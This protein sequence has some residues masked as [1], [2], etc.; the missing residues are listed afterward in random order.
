MKKT[1]IPG[2]F[3]L[4]CLGSTLTQA[5]S[6]KDKEDLSTGELLVQTTGSELAPGS[7]PGAAQSLNRAVLAQDGIGNRG[8]IDQR[9][10]GAGRGNA[11]TIAQDGNGNAAAILQNGFG[12]RTTIVQL[13]NNNTA[14]SEINGRNTESDIL[15][16]G[17][18]NRVDQR[19][20]VD[21]RRYSVE[22][23]GN[24]NQLVQRENG[25]HTP[26]YGVSMKG[27]GIRVIVEQGKVSAM[28]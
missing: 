17:N 3:V 25:S 7:E 14:A 9:L 15:Q 11:A 4:L 6:K 24:N 27:E 5:Q 19:L 2:L 16:K 23:M 26:G 10:L 28:P 8:T 20:N 18:N 21:D 1:L 22:Q 12:N 13:G